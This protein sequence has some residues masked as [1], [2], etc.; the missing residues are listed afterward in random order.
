M[1]KK[2]ENN[3]E[4]E[5]STWTKVRNTLDK[6]RNVPALK[7][8]AETRNGNVYLEFNCEKDKAEMIKVLNKKMDLET[9]EVEKKINPIMIISGIKEGWKEEDLIKEIVKRNEIILGQ[10]KEAEKKM[11]VINKRKTRTGKKENWLIEMRPE[12]FKIFE[13]VESIVIDYVIVPIKEYINLAICYKCCRYGHVAKYC[14]HEAS[15]YNCGG[16]HEGNN[17]E[18]RNMNCINCEYAEI[19]YRTHD[20]RD[21]RCPV[22]K[23]KMDEERGKINYG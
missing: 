8:V 2:R 14:E 12:I 17:C 18:E 5:E 3:K 10:D 4:D 21:I 20:A 16:K 15:C 9:K 6:Y 13:K 22:Y 1:V 23:R 11:K 19:E 7:R